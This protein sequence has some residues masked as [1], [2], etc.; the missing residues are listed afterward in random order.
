MSC[1]VLFAL[2]TLGFSPNATQAQSAAVGTP[3]AYWEF[4]NDA[5]TVDS[6]G[7][8]NELVNVGV[9]WVDEGHDGAAGG[10]GSAYFDGTSYLATLNT[11][12]LSAAKAIRISY[13]AK[14][15]AGNEG[16][17]LEHS[18]DCN[19]TPGGFYAYTGNHAGPSTP[20]CTSFHYDSTGDNLHILP[21]TADTW[22]KH[23][24]EVRPQETDEALVTQTWI[25]GVQIPS[26][27]MVWG[28]E[29]VGAGTVTQNF[30]D[31]LFYVGARDGWNFVMNAL[32]D[33]MKNRRSHRK[34]HDCP[35]GIQ[36]DGFICGLL[37]QRS[38]LDRTRGSW[39]FN[40]FLHGGLRRIRFWQR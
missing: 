29:S 1:V 17:L 7:N 22:E 14:V 5:L 13:W 24:I 23:V 36:L 21:Y 26:N 35:L 11:L 18:N 33:D 25:N 38:Q 2:L 19:A 40:P 30:A 12:D 37:G 9:T 10:A 27:E 20:G 6:T 15:T 4:N 16:I 34:F 28:R 8:G 39:R 32:I 31:D 3:I